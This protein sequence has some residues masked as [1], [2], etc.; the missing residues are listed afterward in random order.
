MVKSAWS[1]FATPEGMVGDLEKRH[2]IHAGDVETS[3]MLHFQ[4]ELVD[5]QKAE[6]FR[7]IAARDEQRFKYLRPTGQHAYGWIASDLNPGGAVGNATN[8]T[9]DRGQSQLRETP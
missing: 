6:D 1:S 3:E 5:M 9:A 4:P 2:G 7:S 8:A